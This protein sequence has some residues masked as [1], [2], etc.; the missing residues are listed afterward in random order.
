MSDEEKLFHVLDQT[1]AMLVQ[2]Q[3]MHEARA[4][5]GGTHGKRI[6]GARAQECANILGE[7]YKIILRY[8]DE[9]V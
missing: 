7:M 6:N 8:S 9:A 2:R 3:L 4:K 1:R 5:S